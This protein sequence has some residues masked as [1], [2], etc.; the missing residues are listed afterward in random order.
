MNF[1]SPMA[2]W[3]LGLAPLIIL[4]YLLKM[5]RKPQIVSSTLLWFRA[6]QDL[7]ANTPF[8][9]LR[10][11]LLLLVQLLILLLL[12]F[13]LARPY[14][15]AESDI[16]RSFVVI[17]DTSASMQAVDESPSRFEAAR[18]IADTLI[19]DLGEGDQLMLIASSSK[20]QVVQSFS[21]NKDELHRSLAALQP[22]DTET[23][24]AEAFLLAQ[25]LLQNQ[26]GGEMVLLSDGGFD[27]LPP[28]AASGVELRYVPVG[29]RSDNLA[30]TALDIRPDPSIAGAY[31][32]F[33]S[34][35]SFSPV[36]RSTGIDLFL[37]DELVDS[38]EV[39]LAPGES[40]A[41][42][43]RIAGAE[44]EVM[45]VRL[46]VEDDLA[47]DNV[48]YAVFTPDEITEVL[49]MGEPNYFL[50]RA[51]ALESRVNLSVRYQDEDFDSSHYDLVIF[52]G[53]C[54]KSPPRNIHS[55]Y[56]NC[57][58]ENWNAALQEPVQEYPP[59]IDW[60]RTHPLLRFVNLENVSI[61]RS[62][63][64]QPPPASE[65]LIES[66]DFPLMSLAIE[67]G[68]YFLLF[69]AFSLNETNWLLR[70]SFP[71][72]ISNLVDYCRDRAGG[73]SFSQL[74]TG[75]PAPLFTGARAIDRFQVHTPSGDV[76]PV[77]AISDPVYFTATE[78]VGLYRVT[79]SDG[80]EDY[81]AVN[82]LSARESNLVPRRDI[83]VGQDA[84]AA[85]DA[86]LKTNREYWKSLAWA[87]LLLLLLEWWIY[88]RRIG[89]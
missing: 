56:F 65:I 22:T 7:E 61:S 59:I 27:A 55:V 85:Q 70:A 21:R 6:V 35:S 12:I 2:F 49:L 1:L 44:Q 46:D 45:K 64:L 14:L 8:Q 24:M 53:R 40:S 3:L 57:V 34:V 82:L 15:R 13:A 43:F 74:T 41:Q 83:Q 81:F 76:H 25:S 84:V 5:K 17:L 9:R 16:A 75:R 86:Q 63:R 58:P 39:T 29:K 66:L 67:Q 72:F 79:A 78:Q 10:R 69:A 47:V 87:A 38:H 26:A 31:Q 37:D 28:L 50:E 51:L 71:I 11:N 88:H 19:R 73:Q 80:R 20:A 60:H 54:P 42:L 77:P 52:N 30:L 4:L 33:V 18:K 23:D 48:A 36:E 62:H 89:V 68:R 32:L